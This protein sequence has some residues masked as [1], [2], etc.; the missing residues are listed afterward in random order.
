MGLLTT[1]AMAERLGVPRKF[2][3]E[4]APE[5]EWHHARIA[6]HIGRIYYYE[7]RLLEHWFTG[8]RGR[9][10]WKMWCEKCDQA[11]SALEP[12]STG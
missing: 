11:E 1:D 4:C 7:P 2:I 8:K 5:C 12:A 9:R 6:D 3:V 10:V